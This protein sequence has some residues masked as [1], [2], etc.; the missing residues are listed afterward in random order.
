MR[1]PIR[2]LASRIVTSNPVSESRFPQVRPLTPAPI[3]T[4]SVTIFPPRLVSLLWSLMYYRRYRGQSQQEIGWTG[5]MDGFATT[6]GLPPDIIHPFSPH[7]RVNPYPAYGWLLVNAPVY[8][9]KFTGLWLVTSHSGCSAAVRDPRFSA[10]QGQRLRIRD[11][12][13]P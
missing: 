6:Q 11:E 13:L 10:A 1:P 12:A 4:T 2:S 7:G 5:Q 9:D 8:F 3:T